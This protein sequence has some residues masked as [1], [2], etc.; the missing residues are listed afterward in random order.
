LQPERATCIAM[1]DTPADPTPYA[2]PPAAA[3]D[4]DVRFVEGTTVD[5]VLL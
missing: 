5:G 2:A 1:T 3:T 4:S